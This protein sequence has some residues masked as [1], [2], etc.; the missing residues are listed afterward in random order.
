MTQYGITN[1]IG[2]GVN[3]DRL[4]FSGQNGDE[5]DEPERGRWGLGAKRSEGKERILN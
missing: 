2:V 3:I 5:R 4:E 1:A